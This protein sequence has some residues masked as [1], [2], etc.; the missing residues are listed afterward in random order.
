MNTYSIVCASNL[1]LTCVQ[2]H[3]KKEEEMGLM[4]STKWPRLGYTPCKN[5]VAEAVKGDPLHKFRCK[6][7]SIRSFSHPL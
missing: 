3:W 1:D 6:N 5:G 2:A 4:D 7:V